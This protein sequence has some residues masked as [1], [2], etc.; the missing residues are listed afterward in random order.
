MSSVRFFQGTQLNE[1]SF[2]ILK[3][4]ETTEKLDIGQSTLRTLDQNF[5]IKVT[6][7]FRVSSCSNLESIEGISFNDQMKMVNVFNCEN[8]KGPI[9]NF[10]NITES[11]TF[12]FSGNDFITDLPPIP[13]LRKVNYLELNNIADLSDLSR[14]SNI[15]VARQLDLADLNINSLDGLN[16]DL[17][18]DSDFLLAFIRLPNLENFS[19]IPAIEKAGIILVRDCS[20]LNSLIG[21]EFLKE[22]D[23]I[24]ELSDLP[25]LKNIN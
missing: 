16:L 6:S 11:E 12:R 21:L 4:V 23:N 10:E 5:Q 25:S 9:D 14:I 3:E 22:V 13:L 17:N 19:G 24:I 1:S 15:E 20:S 7:E 18:S 2:D 8:I